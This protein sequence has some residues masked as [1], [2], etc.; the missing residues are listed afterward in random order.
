VA[1]DFLGYRGS[2]E[3]HDGT[4]AAVL[5]EGATVIVTV[6]AWD[7]RR[8]SI[9]FEGVEDVSENRSEGMML[10]A[11]AEVAAPSRCGASSS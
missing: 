8:L 1:D 5:R 3:I 2:P 7:G 9:R 4:V 11:L 6:D 10:Y